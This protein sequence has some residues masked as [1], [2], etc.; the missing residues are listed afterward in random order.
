MF[1]CL[2]ES[3]YSCC[4]VRLNIAVLEGTRI[5]SYSQSHKS[6]IRD[7]H[8]SINVQ[9]MLTPFS[10]TSETTT[11]TTLS[12]GCGSDYGQAY[13]VW[14]W[15]PQM[16]ASWCSISHASRRKASLRSSAL[17]SSM[18]L[19]KRWSS[20]PITTSLTRI[21]TPTW[22]LNTIAAAC[23]VCSLCILSL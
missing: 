11:S 7:R 22:S 23:L 13:S 10:L 15:S 18:T 1:P 8:K 5:N 9:W 14:C 2:A 19:S 4:T 20:W 21:T 6:K 3:V 12:S 17:S 16:P